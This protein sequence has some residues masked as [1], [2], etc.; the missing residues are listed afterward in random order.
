MEP[1]AD[2]SDVRSG[3][4]TQSSEP[5]TTSASPG[6]RP[7]E[8]YGL[9]ATGFAALIIISFG[10]SVLLAWQIR[11]AR[12]QTAQ[13][14][15]LVANYQKLDEAQVK[16]VLSKLA[17]F[18]VQHPAAAA[19]LQKYPMFF[20]ARPLTNTP[21]AQPSQSNRAPAAP[22]AGVKASGK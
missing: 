13:S 12:A 4:P 8:I 21:T 18:A 6:E 3:I 11:V 7:P 1:N 5:I 9:L 2:S 22:A 20:Q 10:L 15:A 17:A 14:R 16:M 19:I